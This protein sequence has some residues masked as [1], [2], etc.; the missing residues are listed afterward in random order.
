MAS[1]GGPAVVGAGREL[2][3]AAMEGPWVALVIALTECCVRMSQDRNRD[4][5]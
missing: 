3:C 2:R 4:H 1:E 5:L